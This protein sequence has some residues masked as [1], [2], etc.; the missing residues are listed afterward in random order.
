MYNTINKNWVEISV[1]NPSAFEG[2]MCHSASLYGERIYIY[3][4]MKNADVTL[5][6]VSVLCLDGVTEDLENGMV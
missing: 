2:R 4:G 3:G 6:S 1:K 5:D